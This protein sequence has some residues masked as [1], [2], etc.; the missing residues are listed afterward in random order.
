MNWL[1]QR[2]HELVYLEIGE[3]F[4]H[5]AVDLTDWQASRFAVL[6]S[7]EDQDAAIMKETFLTLAFI[8][9][10]STPGENH[11]ILH[12]VASNMVM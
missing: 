7:Q 10:Q 3:V 1:L 4:S 11:R 8:Y 2:K 12:I 5:E 6:Q 9:M